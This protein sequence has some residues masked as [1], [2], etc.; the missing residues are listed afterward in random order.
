MT[1]DNQSQISPSV[2]SQV[3]MCAPFM[4]G[5]VQETV[6]ECLY[7][8]KQLKLVSYNLGFTNTQIKLLYIF[9]LVCS[10]V[11]TALTLTT[12]VASTAVTDVDDLQQESITTLI[13]TVECNIL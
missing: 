6:Q 10:G 7:P 9:S 5:S 3:W 8:V 4:W 11:N 12:S 13:G 1:Q 2:Y